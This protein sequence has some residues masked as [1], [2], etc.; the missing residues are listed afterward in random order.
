MTQQKTK[1]QELKIEWLR[2]RIE[3]GQTE[4]NKQMQRIGL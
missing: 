3:Y 2:K 4:R 1:K